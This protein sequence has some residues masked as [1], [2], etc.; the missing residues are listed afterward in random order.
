MAFHHCALT[1]VHVDQ[2]AFWQIRARVAVFACE[3]HT[4]KNFME[5]LNFSR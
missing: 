1:A 4:G 5:D 2:V 3:G